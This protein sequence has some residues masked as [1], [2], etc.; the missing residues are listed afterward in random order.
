M[1]ALTDA[2]WEHLTRPVEAVRPHGKTRHCSG[3]GAQIVARGFGEA[4]D[5]V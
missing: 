5:G 1:G 4:W 2:Q 3:L